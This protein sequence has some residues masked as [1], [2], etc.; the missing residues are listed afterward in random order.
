MNT[1]RFSRK[2]NEI[3]TYFAYYRENIL[4]VSFGAEFCG[5]VPLSFPQLLRSQIR[6]PTC[7]YVWILLTMSRVLPP[8]GCGNFS[9]LSV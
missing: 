7:K 1:S 6:V 2:Y 4:Y 9:D 8:R 5:S 3:F